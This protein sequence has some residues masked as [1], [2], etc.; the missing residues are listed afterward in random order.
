[1]FIDEVT[2]SVFA[3]NG[4]KG[5]VA[6]N[7]NLMSLGPTGGSGGKGGSIYA[8]GVS[9]LSALQQFR[10]KKVLR[11]QHGM[12]AK[13]QFRDGHDGEDLII[14]V[15]VGTV[16]QNLTD[17]NNVEIV[18]IGEHVL[19]AKGGN[20]G[21][22][23]FLFRSSKNTTPMQFQ[24][25]LPGEEFKLRL[26]LKLIADIGL[27]GLP[28]AGKSSLLNEL[29]SAKSRV[30][31]YPF[32]TLEP[33]LGVY[34]ELV[35]AD[36]P[37]LIEGSSGGKGLGIKFLRHIERVGIIFHLISAESDTP[38][39]DY[40]VIR[41]ELGDYNKAL[42]DKPEYLFLSKSDS[43][44]PLAIKKKLATLKKLNSNVIAISILD[45]ERLKEVKDI[46]NKI[47]EEKYRS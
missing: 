38:A 23:N 1:M 37:G 34:Y 24:Q 18:K 43:A 8:Y 39:E 6:F 25:G 17:R 19:L 46:L 9:D 3:G 40:K 22:G 15:P 27:V 47:K 28:N 14:N 33:N 26:E 44:S 20:G 29:T 36:I 30:A 32:T 45:D 4:G 35:I 11:A 7:K 2:I 12:N 10:H 42:L 21:K 41:K 5:A 13:E 16:I 31:D